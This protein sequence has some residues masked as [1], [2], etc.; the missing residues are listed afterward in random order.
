MHF[1]RS[2]HA[3]IGAALALGMALPTAAQQPTGLALDFLNDVTD[4]ESK[5]VGLARAM[6]AETYDWRPAEGVRS[7]GEVYLH[8]ASNNW[9]LAGEA[10]E[11]APAETG[12][13]KGDYSSVQRY[14][15]KELSKDQIVAELERS[16]A[17]L[18]KTLQSTPPNGLDQTVDFFGNRSPLRRVWVLTVTHMHEHLGQSIAYARSN[19]VVPPWSR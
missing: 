3:A 9:F 2:I 4:V 10:G 11:A 8:I 6:P 14:E 18:K 19:S 5:V 12:I 7:V 16:F 17:F 1:R 13:V 15:A